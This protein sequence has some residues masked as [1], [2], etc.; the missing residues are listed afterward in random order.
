M[1]HDPGECHAL[2]LPEKEQNQWLRRVNRAAG[3]SSSGS[4]N[5]SA[6]H[7]GGGALAARGHSYHGSSAAI[8]SHS[9]SEG[10]SMTLS[11]PHSFHSGHGVVASR[12]PLSPMS[13]RTVPRDSEAAGPWSPVATDGGH[14]NKVVLWGIMA[15]LFFF[16]PC[17]VFFHLWT[18]IQMGTTGRSSVVA[19]TMS[20]GRYSGSE[21][22]LYSG[23]EDCV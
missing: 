23:I 11:P 17:F 12:E 4:P 5:S 2:K 20:S 13:L 8:V 21:A 10:G 16:F 3:L 7:S 9:S 19:P 14:V 15:F 6:T 18:Q 22:K 1:F